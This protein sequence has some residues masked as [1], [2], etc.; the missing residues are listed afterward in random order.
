MIVMHMM[1]HKSLMGVK[2][3]V[4]HYSSDISSLRKSY[5]VKIDFQRYHSLMFAYV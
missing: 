2:F 5:S 4:Q 3:C 1:F